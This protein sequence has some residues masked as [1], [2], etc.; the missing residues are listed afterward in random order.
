MKLAFDLDGV[1]REN[2]L[3]FLKLCLW[4]KEPEAI[5][6]L[7]IKYIS[8]RKPLLNPADFATEDDQI[9]VISNCMTKDSMD[10]KRRWLN[11]Y[12]SCK[13]TFIPVQIATG[14]WK[15]AYCDPVAKG[16]VEVMLNL[17]IDV[18]FDDD[19][20]IIRVMRKLTK[21]IKFVKYGPWIKEYY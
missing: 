9:Y 11:H 21:K 19:P 15:K 4:L 18:Y 3:G 7:K 6:A 13:I 12:F 14:D 1:V 16:K 8:S 2:D 17:G 5:E 10:E 20:A